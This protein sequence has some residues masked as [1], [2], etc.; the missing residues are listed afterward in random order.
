MSSCFVGVN[1][2]MMMM[3]M[4]MTYFVFDVS[5]YFHQ[6]MLEVNQHIRTLAVDASG[7]QDMA[8]IF[9]SPNQAPDDTDTEFDTS[10]DRFDR[11]F[12]YF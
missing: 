2:L 4:M 9:E 12:H 3:M 7:D 10:M 1:V 6:S 8:V 5:A 11:F